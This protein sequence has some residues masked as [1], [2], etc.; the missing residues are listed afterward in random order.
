METYSLLRQLAD[1]WGLLLMFVVFL[2]VIAWAF[3]PGS[4]ETH[5]DIANSIFRNERLPLAEAP[6]PDRTE[7]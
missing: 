7:A 4:R 3:R 2:A 1:S 5:G 6:Q